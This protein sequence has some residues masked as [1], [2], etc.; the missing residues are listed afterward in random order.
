MLN[1]NILKSLSISLL[2]CPLLSSAMELQIPSGKLKNNQNGILDYKSDIYVP[3]MAWIELKPYLE[4]LVQAI[5]VDPMYEEVNIHFKRLG[6]DAADYFVWK[7]N[8]QK[9]FRHPI[10]IGSGNNGSEGSKVDGEYEKYHSFLH[11]GNRTK[12]EERA[13][14]LPY[15]IFGGK[16]DESQMNQKTFINV[17]ANVGF[18]SDDFAEGKHGYQDQIYVKPIHLNNKILDACAVEMKEVILS[19]LEKVG[20]PYVTFIIELDKNVSYTISDLSSYAGRESFFHEIEPLA[21]I[22]APDENRIYVVYY[23]DKRATLDLHGLSLKEAKEKVINFITEKYNNFET[24]CTVITGRGNHTNAN[25]SA[26][27]FKKTLPAWLKSD[28]LRFYV[29]DYKLCNGGGLYKIALVEPVHINLNTQLFEEDVEKVIWF[30]LKQDEN[31]CNRLRIMHENHT[32]AYID[33][34]LMKV[35]LQLSRMPSALKSYDYGMTPTAHNLMWYE[36]EESS[37]EE[38]DVFIQGPNL[39]KKNNNR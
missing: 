38:S 34:V 10:S 1:P 19:T 31:G 11:I 17:M 16:F 33:K 5:T 3:E 21:K 22:I 14:V 37:G 36:Q 9:G 35:M 27:I 29:Q 39:S 15:K 7:K 28:A 6:K 32:S 26:G 25:G 24:E 13:R 20:Q 18:S 23:N 2:M 12:I 30:I 4:N 8:L